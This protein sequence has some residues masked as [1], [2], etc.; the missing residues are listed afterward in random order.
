M[1]RILGSAALFLVIALPSG[2]QSVDRP[3]DV[4]GVVSAGFAA[5]ETKGLRAA[6]AV[7]LEGSPASNAATTEQ[8][9]ATLTPVE[10]AY[11]S[12]MGHEIVRVVPVTPSLRRVYAI[13]RYERGPLFI[14]F[15][16][17]RTGKDWI[18][19][20]V[21]TNTRAAEI[22]PAALLAGER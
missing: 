4:P 7:W 17:Y 15:D 20:M 2:G 22:L 5:Y 14:S 12:L 1:K 16:C 11:G 3:T 19:P 10:T 8:M 21:F 18:I 6:L 13:I 9:I